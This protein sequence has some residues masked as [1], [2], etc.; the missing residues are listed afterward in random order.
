MITNKSVRE[1]FEIDNY[2][3]GYQTDLE[4]YGGGFHEI[5]E[6]EFCCVCNI[7]D[8]VMHNVW[9]E[10][11][12]NVFIDNY[13]ELE[14]DVFSSYNAI[15]ESQS[16]ESNQKSLCI[17]TI[18]L[19]NRRLLNFL[20]SARMYL[21]QVEHDLS[22]VDKKESS[23][24]KEEFKQNKNMEYDNCIGYQVM[25]L[26]RDLSQ[27]QCMPI[28]KIIAYIPMLEWKSD[29]MPIIIEFDL[30]ILKNYSTFKAKIK[31]KFKISNLLDYNTDRLNI[32]P[33]IR[34]YF[35]SICNIH[36]KYRTMTEELLLSKIHS[37]GTIFDKYNLS[38]MNQIA[39]C[40][41]SE[42]NDLKEYRLVEMGNFDSILIGR[43]K[44]NFIENNYFISNKPFVSSKFVKVQNC[45]TVESKISH[46]IN[47]GIN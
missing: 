28:D 38:K 22:S 24:L 25:E 14:K 2:K 23:N 7:Y 47:Y 42:S 20:S 9:I 3:Y 13:I 41:L 15:K 17:S 4:I 1:L 10:E 44:D 30:K 16:N 19:L 27:H 32:T 26:L 21:D 18:K 33:Y 8:F 5:L 45:C 39:F 29:Y 40:K 35:L 46:N 12:F 43:K 37:I 31:K 36:K 11:K 34:E 6:T